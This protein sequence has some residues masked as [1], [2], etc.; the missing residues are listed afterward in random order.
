M[1]SM[2]EHKFHFIGQKIQ[3]HLQKYQFSFWKLQAIF[4]LFDEIKFILFNNIPEGYLN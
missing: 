3:L 4:F 2:V 1:V